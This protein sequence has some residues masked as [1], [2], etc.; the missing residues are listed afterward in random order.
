MIASCTRCGT[1]FDAQ[2]P[3]AKYCTASCRALASREFKRAAEVGEHVA[4][5]NVVAMT[6][7]RTPARGRRVTSIEAALVRELGAAA[8]TSIGQQALLLARRMD[9]AD[10]SGAALANMSKQL[11]ILTS[12]ARRDST[13]DAAVDP[14]AAVQAQ[15]IAIRKSNAG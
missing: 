13:P 3:T 15:V 2:R 7:R 8:N 9:A 6:A 10:D 14:V 11:V 4:A 5:A 1:E 12:A